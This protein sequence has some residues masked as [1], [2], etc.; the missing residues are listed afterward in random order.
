LKGH[1]NLSWTGDATKRKVSISNLEL[2]LL[3][4]KFKLFQLKVSG[5]FC[6]CLLCNATKSEL[7]MTAFECWWD[8]NENTRSSQSRRKMKQITGQA[9]STQHNVCYTSDFCLRC[10]I[11]HYSE[12]LCGLEAS[13]NVLL[14]LRYFVD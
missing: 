4:K 9:Y 8:D 1:H 10:S 11:L 12:I 5:N 13:S 6:H 7:T 3:S 14:M 2:K